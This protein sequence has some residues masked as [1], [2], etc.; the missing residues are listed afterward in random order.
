MF[1]SPFFIILEP[2]TVNFNSNR[3]YLKNKINVQGKARNGEK[4][5]PTRSM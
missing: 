1:R 2:T 3:T 5:E 4:A